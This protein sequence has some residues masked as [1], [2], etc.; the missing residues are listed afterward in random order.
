[1]VCLQVDQ[2]V[3]DLTYNWL[4]S[5]WNSIDT[6]D[7]TKS[8]TKIAQLLFQYLNLNSTNL[9]QIYLALMSVNEKQG[10]T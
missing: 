4:K 7:V 9:N 3:Q 8:Q 6:T 10:M 2:Q 5:K 1:M